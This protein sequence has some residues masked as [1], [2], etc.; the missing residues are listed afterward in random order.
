MIERSNKKEGMG[1]KDFSH[2]CLLLCFM[3]RMGEGDEV[4]RM[5]MG[6]S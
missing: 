1:E 4:E 3:G 5:G 2:Q 6:L